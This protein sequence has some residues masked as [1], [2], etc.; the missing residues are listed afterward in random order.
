MVRL[1]SRGVS[2][3]FSRLVSINLERIDFF[4][5][6]Q[7]RSRSAERTSRCRDSKR[8]AIGNYFSVWISYK[9]QISICIG[10]Q[11]WR[12]C[13]FWHLA[14]IMPLC[15]ARI[16]SELRRLACWKQIYPL[17]CSILHHGVKNCT[18][19]DLNL[20]YNLRLG[21]YMIFARKNN[22]LDPLARFLLFVC[23]CLSA[24][25]RPLLFVCGTTDQPSS[26]WDC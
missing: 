15:N 8:W 3:F 14:K 16:G 23:F 6:F 12:L 13:S 24:P 2:W 17:S 9:L 20:L 11:A 25:C 4:T 1:R 18:D 22:F 5:R 26:V 19:L 21:T 10:E 7:F